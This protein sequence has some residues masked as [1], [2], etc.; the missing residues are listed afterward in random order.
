MVI[1]TP[2]DIKSLDYLEIESK[3][4]EPFSDILVDFVN[5]VSKAILKD[6]FFKQYP[7]LMA[8]AFWMR[9]S[10]IKELKRYFIEQKKDKLLIGRGIVFHM[11]PSN[12]DTIFVYSWFISLLV[13]NS[14]VLRISDKE[15]IQTELL[16]NVIVSVLYSQKYEVLQN[17]VAIIRYGHIDEITQKLSLM[18]DV[19]VIWGGDSTV[20][21]IRTIPIKPTATELTFA[22]KFS[23]AVIKSTELLKNKNI[24]LLIEKFY[25]DSFWFGQMACSSIRLVVWAGDNNENEKAKK[26]FW[27]KFKTYVSSQQPEE[28]SPADI[29]NKLVAECSIAIENSV[30]IENIENPYINK[31]KIKNIS[32]I[33]EDLHCGTGLF[34]ELNIE[35]FEDILPYMT[36]KHQTVA[37]YGFSHE[38]LRKMIYKNMPEGI[39]RIVPIGKSLDF[40]YI[41][42]GYDLFRSFCRE[43]EIK[44]A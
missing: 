26:L 15:N 27:D 30:E 6:S 39:D 16:L 22:D 7:E 3:V 35:N 8:L 37:Q 21:H 42:D 43:I 33:N 4:L 19:R 11:A 44:E 13:G 28:I 29:V 12:V 18:A 17:R 34:Y 5:D 9:K 36:K 23:F 25:N 14:N 41:W 2:K 20:N 31:I 1:V 38:E 40:S 32:E 24:D 10:H